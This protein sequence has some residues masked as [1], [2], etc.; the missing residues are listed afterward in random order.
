MPTFID[1]PF[2][3]KAAYES[4]QKLPEAEQ[5]AAWAAAASGSCNKL[6]MVAKRPGLTWLPACEPVPPGHL[7]LQR[8]R[9]PR[10]D[11]R[12][13]LP[14]LQTKASGHDLGD[15]RNIP[16][17]GLGL[18]YTPPGAATYDIVAAALKLGYRSVSHAAPCCVPLS[19]GHHP[20]PPPQAS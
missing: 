15:G 4:Y 13:R 18:Y 17:V 7:W 8:H 10:S 1:S 9:C 6:N 2:P 20:S 16:V 12:A 14:L 19:R 11:P 5:A 3:T